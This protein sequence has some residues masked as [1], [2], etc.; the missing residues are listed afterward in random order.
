VGSVEQENSDANVFTEEQKVLSQIKAAAENK[1]TS[2]TISIYEYAQLVSHYERLLKTTKKISK[3]S[4]IQGRTLKDQ[5]HKIQEA[6]EHLLHEEH[7][8][9]QIISDVCHELGNPMMAIQSYLKAVIDGMLDVDIAYLKLMH[10]KLTLTNQ[11]IEDLFLL[12]TSEDN[13][14]LYQFQEMSLKSMIA[15]MEDKYLLHVERGSQLVLDNRVTSEDKGR[16]WADPMRI[17]QVLH[18]LIDNALK[19]TPSGEIVHIQLEA[20]NQQLTIRVIDHGS[21]INQ[22]ELPYIFD[23]YYR[24]ADPTNAAIKGTGLGLAICREIIHKHGGE[25]GVLSEPGQGST[26]YF[27]LPFRSDNLTS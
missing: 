17:E 3:I 2:E 24:S 26:F 10:D 5:K 12:S 27:T 23:R 15:S 25:I 14:A 18:N 16:V 6:N 4:D 19:Y 8:R 13:K 21:G 7:L 22:K 9:K 20:G 11:L 1:N